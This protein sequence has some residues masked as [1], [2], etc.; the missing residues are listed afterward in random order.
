MHTRKENTIK[1][2]WQGIP[3]KFFPAQSP[4]AIW[5]TGGKIHFCF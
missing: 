4:A 1:I 5:S 2:N 3:K